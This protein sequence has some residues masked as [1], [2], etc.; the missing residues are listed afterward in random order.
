MYCP[1]MSEFAGRTA[2]ITG[3]SSG[4]GAAVARDLAEAGAHVV[5][6]GRRAAAAD[7]IVAGIANDGGSAEF[8]IADI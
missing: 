5:I 3:G 4:I 8:V 7:A 2:V 6:V 1:F